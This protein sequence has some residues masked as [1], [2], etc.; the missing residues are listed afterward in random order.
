[1]GVLKFLITCLLSKNTS[2]GTSNGTLKYLNLYLKASIIYVVT[3]RAKKSDPKLEVSTESW[4]LL[5]H[6]IGALLTYMMISIMQPPI[7]HFSCMIVIHKI[8][9]HN[10]LIKVFFNT[11]WYNFLIIRLEVFSIIKIYSNNVKNI[12][13]YRFIHGIACHSTW[14]VTQVLLKIP[15]DKINSIKITSPGEQN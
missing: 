1:M 9:H 6:I 5:Y 12:L 3:L 13:I 4:G 7:C 8:F 14:V 2:L 10:I 11:P 15:E